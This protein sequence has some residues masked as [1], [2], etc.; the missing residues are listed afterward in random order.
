MNSSKVCRSSTF[1]SEA[2]KKAKEWLLAA[3]GLALIPP[4]LIEKTWTE[5]MDE[6]T[7]DHRSS[8]KFNDYMV[9]TYVDI[10]SSRYSIE[11]WNVNNALLKNLPRT[12]NHVEGNNSRLGSLFPIR[13]HLFRFIELLRDEHV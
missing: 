2:R 10:T 13:P 4:N 5:A 9:S 7:P 11:L 1:S 12:N 6:I 3:I 8:V